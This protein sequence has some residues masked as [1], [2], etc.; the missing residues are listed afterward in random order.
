MNIK[1][2]KI[3]MSPSSTHSKTKL[4]I[5]SLIA[6]LLFFLC[7]EIITRIAVSITTK[8]GNFILYGIVKENHELEP[9]YQRI[10]GADGKELYHKLIPSHDPRNPANRLGFRGPE[11]KGKDANTVRVVCLGGSTTFGLGLYYEDTYPKLL[12]NRLNHLSRNPNFEVINAGMPALV[13]REI[14]ELI[15]HE[16]QHLQP[17]IIILMSIINNLQTPEF[18]F[19]SFFEIAGQE[20][21][22]PLRWARKFKGILVNHSVLI[23]SID[24]ILTR[25]VRQY[26]RNF[27]WEGFGNALLTSDTVWDTYLTNL[28]KLLEVIFQ[29]NPHCKVVLLGEPLNIIDY[30]EMEQP[31]VRATEILLKISKTNSHLRFID[32]RDVFL[33]AQ[34]SGKHVW[35]APY[36]DPMHLTKDGNQVLAE[37]VARDILLEEKGHS[38]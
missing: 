27:N 6:A 28:K 9:K 1:N 17:D 8:S 32:V 20:R 19:Y 14:T 23:Y 29:N 11:I 16:I 36:Y 3:V 24:N 31:Y 25:G 34:K 21:S 10:K 37:L 7:A 18:N 12:E 4:L 38:K 15:R 30:P 33:N 26:N 35:V 5:F 13:L 2:K 22:M